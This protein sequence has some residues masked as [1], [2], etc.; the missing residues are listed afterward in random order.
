[1]NL[2]RLKFAWARGARAQINIS[3]GWIDT[4]IDS[5]YGNERRIHPD[6]EHLQYGPVSTAMLELAL[7]PEFSAKGYAANQL[8][9]A[10]FGYGDYYEGD[11]NEWNFF[12]LFVAEL[13]AD[14]GL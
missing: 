2:Q 6:D 10:L 7:Y 14:E 5:V 8:S 3:S 4:S 1:M 13:L 12:Y 9:L 11:N